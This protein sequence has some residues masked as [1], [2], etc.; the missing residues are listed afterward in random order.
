[1]RLKIVALA[2]VC[3]LPACTWVHMAP[4]ASAV[5]VVQGVPAG[6]EKRGEVEVSVKDSVAFYDRNALRVQDELETL[7]RN[8][9]PGLGADTVQALGPPADGSQRYAAW[10]CK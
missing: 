2:L 1:M 4:G 10:K 9:A 6:C 5:T 8:E 7:A 3:T